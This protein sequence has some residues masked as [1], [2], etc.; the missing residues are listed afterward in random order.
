[1]YLLLAPKQ[2]IKF[3]PIITY[4]SESSEFTIVFIPKLFLEVL[5]IQKKKRRLFIYC[6]LKHSVY[7]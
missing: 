4:F 6:L 1:M 7:L 3:D 5:P 2:N